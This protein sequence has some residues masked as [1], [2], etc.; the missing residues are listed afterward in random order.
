MFRLKR[1]LLSFLGASLLAIPL[2]TRALDLSALNA[3][4]NEAFQ[5]FSVIL[6]ALQF[7]LWPILLLLGGLL[8]NDLL[9]SGGMQTVLLNIWSAVRDFVNIMFVLGLLGVAIYNIIGIGNNDSYSVK[10]ALPKIAIALIA[11]N[12]SFLACKVVLDVVNVTTTAIFAVPMASDALAK[13]KDPQQLQTLSNAF[14]NKINNIKSTTG[15][16]NPFCDPAQGSSGSG[17]SGSDTAGAQVKQELNK[18][19]KD[20]FST[21]NSRNA[22]MVMAIELMGIANIDEV[23]VD[24]VSDVKSLTINTLFS[25]IFLAIY[26]TAFVALFAALLVRVIVLWISIAISPLSFLGLAFETVKK[27]FGDDDPF[28]SMFMKSAIVP[29]PVALILTIGMIMITQLKQITPG[30]Q[31][32]TNPADLGAITSGISTIQDLI[33]GLATAGFI[34]IAAFKAMKGPQIDKVVSPIKGAVEGFG[35]NLAKLPLYAPILPVAPGKSVGLAALTS[36]LSA[37][38]AYI[39]KKQGEYAEMFG[40]KSAKTVN[41]LK[42]V[43]NEAEARKAISEAITSNSYRLD[44]EAQ[45]EVAALIEKYKMQNMKLPAGYTDRNKF[46]ADLKE[47]KVGEQAFKDF[48]KVNK[49]VGF[50]APQLDTATSE[51]NAKGAISKAGGKVNP[52]DKKVSGTGMQDLDTATSELNQ[53]LAKLEEAKKNGDDAK[54]AQAKENVD[55]L[56]DRVKKLTDARD[57]VKGSDPSITINKAGSVVAKT[58]AAQIKAN[59]DSVAESEKP[60]AKKMLV[61][62]FAQFLAGPGQTPT[63]QHQ[64]DA[65]KIVDDILAKGSSATGLSAGPAAP[66]PPASPN[67]PNPPGG[68]NPNPNPPKP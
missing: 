43:K 27:N 30:V 39:Q 44:K 19:G 58:S 18:L 57:K 32:S 36:G 4:I 24:S 59:Y 20:F 29:V 25:I 54:V 48:M 40:D 10:K 35:K 37:P 67:P 68:P 14:C 45:A 34:W 51:A 47:G 26:G 50:I 64:A 56:V 42:G 53:E 1:I 15:Q 7:A 13:Y 49:E 9:F 8:N 28:F 5:F 16:K 11:V 62:K 55:R 21:F 3:P 41:K 23:K 46:L 38:A 63:A 60:A 22:A 33:A 61:D 6:S 12:F 52:A 65:A 17:G 66:N 31:L 2:V